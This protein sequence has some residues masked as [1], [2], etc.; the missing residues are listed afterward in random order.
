MTDQIN[1]GLLWASTGGVDPVSAEKYATGWEIEIPTFQN[2]NYVLQNLDQNILALAERGTY[3]W[4]DDVNYKIGA[5]VHVGGVVYTCIG[6]NINSNPVTDKVQWT[7]GGIMGS[8]SVDELLDKEGFKLNKLNE[9]IV[10]TWGGNAMTIENT[11][12]LMA[13]NT[14]GATK[15]WLIGNIGGTMCIVDVG[16]EKVPDGRSVALAEANTYQLYHEGNKPTQADVSGTVASA[17]SDGVMYAQK[18]G[19]WVRVTSTTVSDNAPPPAIGNGEG[20]FNLNDNQLY[21]DIDDGDT[22]QWVPANS[23]LIPAELDDSAGK[24]KELSDAEVVAGTSTE[25][26]TITPKQLHDKIASAVPVYEVLDADDYTNGTATNKLVSGA[27][28]NSAIDARLPVAVREVTSAE[29]AA[30]ISTTKGISSPKQ[31]ADLIDAKGHDVPDQVTN[32]EVTT[33]TSTTAKT[34][35]AAQLKLAAETHA[36]N[37]AAMSDA[38]VTAGTDTT[39]KSVT[40]AQLKLAAETHASDGGVVLD[41]TDP[42]VLVSD[43]EVVTIPACS[44]ARVYLNLAIQDKSQVTYGLDGNNKIISVSVAGSVIGDSLLV[45]TSTN[46]AEYTLPSGGGFD[47]TKRTNVFTGT[48]SSLQTNTF[49]EGFY[50]INDG[51]NGRPPIIYLDGTGLDFTFYESGSSRYNIKVTP[52]GFLALQI[53]IDGVYSSNTSIKTVDK[54]G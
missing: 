8:Q 7:L 3:A 30:A 44:A 10:N 29:M 17:P 20:W 19:V 39:T 50:I 4:Q 2:F 1:L 27:T 32:T 42:Y 33:G 6:A 15:N 9:V 22:S 14:E 23:P 37:V 12:P 38:E 34:V 26:G 11:T 28:L 51:H 16:T 43:A 21:I 47:I 41:W 48:V 31:I 5:K 40:A 53:Y 45:E 13:F 35:S 18:D 25:T 24:A 52:T 54:M 46:T 36:T 49:E